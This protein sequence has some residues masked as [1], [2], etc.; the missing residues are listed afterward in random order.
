MLYY[1]DETEHLLGFGGREIYAYNAKAQYSLSKE[2]ELLIS[3]NINTLD[4]ETH[5]TNCE[6]YKPRFIKI[7]CLS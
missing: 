5:I 2:G 3:Y 6:L 1:T 7:R 4:F